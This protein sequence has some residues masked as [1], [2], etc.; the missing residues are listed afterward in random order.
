MTEIKTYS[1]KEIRKFYNVSRDTFNRWLKPILSDL[2]NY[3][4]NAKLFTPAQVRVIVA[5]LGEWE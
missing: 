4:K 1:K 5:H 2:P 3:D